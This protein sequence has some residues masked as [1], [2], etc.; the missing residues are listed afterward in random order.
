MFKLFSFYLSFVLLLLKCSNGVWTESSEDPEMMKYFPETSSSST[1]DITDTKGM[2]Q[3]NVHLDLVLVLDTTKSIKKNLEAVLKQDI[4]QFLVSL[5]KLYPKIRVGLVTFRDKNLSPFGDPED[6]CYREHSSLT[7]DIGVVASEFMKLN[8]AGGGD[9]PENPLEAVLTCFDSHSNLQWHT[10]NEIDGVPVLKMILVITDAMY[11]IAPHW[12]IKYKEGKVQKRPGN[13][14]TGAPEECA[15]NE[16]PELQTVKNVLQNQNVY[17][18]FL[19][20]QELMDYYASLIRKLSTGAVANADISEKN[21]L[22]KA[23]EIIAKKIERISKS[24]LH[25]EETHEIPLIP[26]PKEDYVD[27]I[28]KKNPKEADEKLSTHTNLKPNIP[29]LPPCKR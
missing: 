1:F 11:K 10:E 12:A 13:P 17:P 15:I 2:I 3:R 4:Y 6:Y 20:P 19:V 28:V 29:V 22:D 5:V 25:L 26:P 23:L 14:S 18:I 21:F 9:G 27:Y 8:A 24:K 16:Y 7:K